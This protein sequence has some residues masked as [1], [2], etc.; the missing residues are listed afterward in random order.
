VSPFFS[1]NN[2][3]VEF[4]RH[5]PYAPNSPVTESLA[6]LQDY[7]G[8]PLSVPN[9]TTFSTGNGPDF[10]SPQ[11]V[12]G[13]PF[14]GATSVPVNAVIRMRFNEPIDPAS[15]NP[16]TT[17]LATA[18]GGNVAVTTT[19]ETD[20]RTITYVPAQALATGQQYT[21]YAFDVRDLSGN[22]ARVYSSFTTGSAADTQA[23]VVMATSIVDGMVN[24][25][26]NAVVSA[27]F[28]EPVNEQ[29]L[30]GITL[31]ANGNPM[32]SSQ[33]LNSNHR[34]VTLKLSQPLLALT[35]YTFAV[36]AVQDLSGNV[37]AS[38]A[39]VS[40]TTG[41]GADLTAPSVLSITPPNNATGVAL[42]SPL[43]ARCSERLMTFTRDF[44][45][46]NVGLLD[47][48]VGQI[49]PG[50][51]SLDADGVTVRFTPAAGGLVANH[52]YEF[53]GSTEDLAGNTC[54]FVTLFDSGIQ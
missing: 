33:L 48:T 29:T 35:T 18:Q 16:A 46:L 28:D 51:A 20:G 11:P 38:P 53:S 52:R 42:N 2:R 27:A 13:T 3:Q 26:T 43:A 9:S 50:V 49:V 45:F 8:N 24:V 12:S 6:A 32:P 47:E 5:D 21:A 7:A 39:T 41:A 54:E 34:V 25:P 22:V 44:E 15:V 17:Y 36:T 1:E 37:L 14:S 23:P 10:T 40:F 19:L 4:K 31:M 30:T